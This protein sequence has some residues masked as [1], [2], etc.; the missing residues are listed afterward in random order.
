MSEGGVYET[1]VIFLR[2]INRTRNPA[3][4]YFPSGVGEGPESILLGAEEQDPAI[5]S[6]S[7]SGE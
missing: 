1:L 2:Y 5:Q 3:G 7:I 4:T 6:K